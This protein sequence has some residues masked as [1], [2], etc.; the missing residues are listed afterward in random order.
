MSYRGT[1]FTPLHFLALLEDERDWFEV[2]A[3]LRRERW[4]Q[5]WPE[6]SREAR[7]VITMLTERA[8][9]LRKLIDKPPGILAG[10]VLI[11]T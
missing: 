11:W 6:G 2:L 3:I 9:R 4:E 7:A 5:A 1:C 10:G 8:S